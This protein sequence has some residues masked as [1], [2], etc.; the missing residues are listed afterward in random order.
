MARLG[1]DIWSD[2]A[3]PWCYIG[4]R[5]LEKAL[6]N[7]P[8]RESVHIVWHAFELNPSAPREDNAGKYSERIAKKYGTSARDAEGMISRMTDV[9]KAEGLNFDFEIIRPGNTFDAHRLLHLA[10]RQGLQDKVKE[11]FLRAYFSEGEGI[12]DTKTLLRL[13]VDA[14]LEAEQVQAVLESDAYAREVREDEAE[15]RELG[16]NGV[17]FFVLAERY[18]VSGAQPSEVLEQALEQAHRAIEEPAPEY[19]EEAVC[20]PDGC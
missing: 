17:P 1:I 5:R 16:I 2:I 18:A 8:G 19:S 12:S 14:G 6:A 7:F 20:G 3:C 9:A 15:A 4:K 10:L 11:R 13:A